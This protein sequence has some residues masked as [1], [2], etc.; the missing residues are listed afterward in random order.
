MD[1][2][3]IN[4]YHRKYYLEHKNS[5]L[6]SKNKWLESKGEEWK[7]K[8]K[9]KIKNYR[10]EYLER[11][12]LQ[13]LTHYGSKCSCELCNFNDFAMKV[14]GSRFIQIDHI[15]GGGY[16]IHKQKRWSYNS[17]KKDNYPSDLRI[18][19][20]A[21]N[22]YMNPSEKIC[23]YHKHLYPAMLIPEFNQIYNMES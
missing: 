20:R 9:E 18:L 7:S 6:F 15:N 3:K 13:V 22:V 1:R 12:A 16:R 5:I 8:N 10:K 4:A 21:C 19:C 17:I 2:E 14:H 11:I 23:E